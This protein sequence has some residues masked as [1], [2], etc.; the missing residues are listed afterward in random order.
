MNTRICVAVLVGL[1]L[2]GQLWVDDSAHAQG[3][4]GR[5][6]G[7]GGQVV[8]ILT[9]PDFQDPPNVDVN[10]CKNDEF[11]SHVSEATGLVKNDQEKVSLEVDGDVVKVV[12][13]SVP[14][15]SI[16]FS[17]FTDEEFEVEY[18]QWLIACAKKGT[19]RPY[20]D[21]SEK[22]YWVRKPTQGS[23]VPGL[24]AQ[25]AAAVTAPDIIWPN[26]DPEHGWIYVNVANDLRIAPKP[27]VRFEV[28]I[29]NITGSVSGWA[30]GTPSLVTF[31][32]GEPG[33]G[34][35]EC[36][37]EAAI[38][39]YD[40]DKPGLCHYRYKK[41]SAIAPGPQ[42]AFVPRTTLSWEITSSAPLAVADGTTWTEEPLQVAEIQAIEVLVQD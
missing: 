3:D 20:E 12:P 25:V 24:L 6:K 18:T 34:R 22:R 16:G 41:S 8:L 32:S 5:K 33:R 40:P 13:D 39:P 29:S 19:D 7:K 23:V 38:E 2:A 11:P 4:G 17:F 30:Q 10:P 37:Y 26:R 15:S 14:G 31:E 27:L 21:G 35:T 1:M 28:T 36:T 9:L 42:H